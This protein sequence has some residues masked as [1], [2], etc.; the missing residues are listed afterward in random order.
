MSDLSEV[1]A[2]HPVPDHRH[3][4][5][6]RKENNRISNHTHTRA[7]NTAFPLHIP[8]Q[9]LSAVRSF[10]VFVSDRRPENMAK[11]PPGGPTANG[12]P[13]RGARR[14]AERPELAA[15]DKGNVR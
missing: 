11:I 4:P 12:N 7:R 6:D 1:G 5:C 9:P 3:T 10:S 15:E 14:G 2:E 8:L 13:R